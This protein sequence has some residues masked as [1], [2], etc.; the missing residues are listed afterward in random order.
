M[1][2][3]VVDFHWCFFLRT[4]DL[5]LLQIGDQC[6]ITYVHRSLVH[7]HN[8]NWDILDPVGNH[9]T[10]DS[11][12]WAHLRYAG[13]PRHFLARKGVD[14]ILCRAESTRF[15]EE[16]PAYTTNVGLGC[17]ACDEFRPTQLLPH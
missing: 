12:A 3:N 17:S 14:P 15:V 8:T 2:C 11:D 16:L 7:V 13:H 4:A 10:M 9:R 6:P 1:P 5:D